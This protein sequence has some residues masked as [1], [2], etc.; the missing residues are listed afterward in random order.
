LEAVDALPP[1]EWPKRLLK[2]RTSRHPEAERRFDQL[3]AHRDRLALEMNLDGS[4]IASRATLEEIAQNIEALPPLLPWQQRLL[5]PA[6]ASLREGD[7]SLRIPAGPV[8]P[9]LDRQG[10]GD[11]PASAL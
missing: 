2:K 3:K 10:D 11:G 6:V 1:E 4:L 8:D 7:Q 9:A 5:L